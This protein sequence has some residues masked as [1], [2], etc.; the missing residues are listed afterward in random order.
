MAQ[1]QNKKP[2][3][4]LKSVKSDIKALGKGKTH[5]QAS[6]PKRRILYFLSCEVEKTKEHV[7]LDRRQTREEVEC[8]CR[9][10]GSYLPLR[11]HPLLSS[12][13]SFQTSKL[14]AILEGRYTRLHVTIHKV[15]CTSQSNAPK[16]PYMI[17]DTNPF[18]LIAHPESQLPLFLFVSL[19]SAPAGQLMHSISTG[20][21]L[22]S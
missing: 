8:S 19:P 22:V 18:E 14:T 12:S 9:S 4:S 7:P 5:Q 21:R 2:M 3:L 10:C 13:F 17:P 6:S 1:T 11:V 20:N 16:H 15:I